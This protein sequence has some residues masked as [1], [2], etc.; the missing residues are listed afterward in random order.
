VVHGGVRRAVEE[1]AVNRPIESNLQVG[2]LASEML[3]ARESL[4]RNIDID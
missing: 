3:Y 1:L 4:D 2:R